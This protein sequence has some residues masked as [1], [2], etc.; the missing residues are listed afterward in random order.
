MTY[1]F[2]KALSCACGEAVQRTT[3]A[4]K[5]AGF[6]IITE[7]TVN[8]TFRTKPDADFRNSAP[9]RSTP[10]ISTGTS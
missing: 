8:E 1:Y 10:C 7:I 9:I 6:G 4:L 2:A 3:P 5:Q